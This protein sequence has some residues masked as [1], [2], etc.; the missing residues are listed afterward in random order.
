MQSYCQCISALSCSYIY[1]GVIVRIIFSFYNDIGCRDRQI[2]LDLEPIGGCRA[3]KS[4]HS[5]ISTAISSSV[6]S[7]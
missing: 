6:S 7:Y 3:G 4:G 1:S 2:M 5:L